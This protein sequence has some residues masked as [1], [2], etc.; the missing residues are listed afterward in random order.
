MS[1]L[2]ERRR[3]RPPDRSHRAERHRPRR[4]P[5]PRRGL[6]GGGVEPPD[7]P[8]LRGLRRPGA[9]RRHPRRP[10]RAR[11]DARPSRPPSPRPTATSWAPTRTACATSRSRRTPCPAAWTSRRAPPGCARP[12]CCSARA[13][14]GLLVHAVALENWQRLHRFCSRC[15]ERTVIAA[16]GHIR[17]CPACG[18]EHYPR[19]DPAVIMLVTDERGPRAAGPPGAL[20][21]GPLLDARGLR[22]AG[23]VDRAVGASARSS[24]RR[25]S[26]SARS[27]TSPAS[28]GRS[29][30]A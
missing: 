25:A 8:G 18:A 7:D 6:A 21:G 14:P 27:S 4:A 26:R 30:P 2:T 9:D 23:R 11:H 19:T 10:H 29:R 20:A 17:R 22:R 15:G 13:T 28:P 1:T 5:P 24:R 12:D 3:P 16:A